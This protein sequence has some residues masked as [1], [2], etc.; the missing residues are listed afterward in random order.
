MSPD[1]ST[2][3]EFWTSLQTVLRTLYRSRLFTVAAMNGHAIAGGCILASC[4]DERILR[5][6]ARIGLNE[7]AFGLLPPPFAEAMFHTI[8]GQRVAER[9]LSLGTLFTAGI[10][11]V[12]F[13]FSLPQ[14]AFRIQVWSCYI[15]RI[16]HLPVQKLLYTDIFTYFDTS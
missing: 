7:A 9:A 11:S 16:Y 14:S 10:L 8:V 5:S 6:K 12:P 3:R 1:E 4:C 15:Y 2:L 13:Y